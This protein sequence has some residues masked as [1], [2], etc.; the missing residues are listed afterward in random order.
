MGLLVGVYLGTFLTRCDL[1]Q[2]ESSRISR[3]SEETILSSIHIFDPAPPG[4]LADGYLRMVNFK[5]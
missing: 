1:F 5:E 4:T 3:S 2:S